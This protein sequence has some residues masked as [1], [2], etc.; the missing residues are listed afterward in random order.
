MLASLELCSGMRE[1]LND[2]VRWLS[3]TK[4]LSPSVVLVAA[5]EP[6]EKL[7]R[8]KLLRPTF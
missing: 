2:H 4:L 8:T 7:N 3:N 6:E 5:F 1:D